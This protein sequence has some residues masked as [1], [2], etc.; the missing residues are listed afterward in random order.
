MGFNDIETNFLH[1]T[2]SVEEIFFLIIVLILLVITCNHHNFYTYEASKV[3]K[4]LII[5]NVQLFFY[6]LLSRVP[7]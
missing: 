1:R 2:S 4:C 7:G 3:K 6:I 5:S